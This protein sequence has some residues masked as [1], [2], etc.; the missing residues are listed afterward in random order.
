MKTKQHLALLGF[1][2]SLTISS[3]VGTQ[4]ALHMSTSN[5]GIDVDTTPP[6]TEIGLSRNELAVQPSFA[7]G[8]TPSSVMSFEGTAGNGWGKGVI[9]NFFFGTGSTFATGQAAAN[10]TANSGGDS[11]EDKASENKEAEATEEAASEGGEVE[12]ATASKTAGGPSKHDTIKLTTLP[13]RPNIFKLIFNPRHRYRPFMEDEMFPLISGTK[14]VFGLD[15]N[16]DPATQAPRA[17][18]AGF[19]RK[20]VSYA[21]LIAKGIKSTDKSTNSEL[22]ANQAPKDPIKIKLPSVIAG[23][24]MN[25]KVDAGVKF[26]HIQFLATGKAAENLGSNSEAQSLLKKKLTAEPEPPA[27][28]GQ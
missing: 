25:T 20:E 27:G 22:P 13:S 1:I 24:Q 5:F 3:C 11:K 21:P 15:V 19:N 6:T 8:Q 23:H 12:N 4:S 14:T 26:S 17:I 10:L 2:T 18:K 9:S 7:N 16:W 28:G